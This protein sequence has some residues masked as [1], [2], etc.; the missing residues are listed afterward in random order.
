MAR[1]QAP[2]TARAADAVDAAVPAD[3]AADAAAGQQAL[4]VPAAADLAA[5]SVADSAAAGADPEAVRAD[6]ADGVL[7][8]AAAVPWAARA[9][10]LSAMRDAIADCS[11][12]EMRLSPW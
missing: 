8:Q 7:E 5:V 12:T 3:L 1:A 2:V 10:L 11:T 9:W 6:V 4:R